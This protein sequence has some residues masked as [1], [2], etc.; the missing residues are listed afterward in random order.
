MVTPDQFRN[1]YKFT[2]V[3]NPWSRVF[4]WYKNVMR[5]EPHRKRLGVPDDCSFGDFLSLDFDQDALRS[6][7][8]WISDGKGQ[9]RMDFIGRFENLAEDFAHVC[10]VL[11]IEDSTLPKLVAGDG[12]HYTDYY[13][14][15]ARE[16]VRRRY[17]DEIALCGFKYG[18]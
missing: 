17:Q 15:K 9:N 10:S 5:F 1:Y 2:F 13:D 8:Y 7:I 18:E 12:S 3:R 16:I 6:Q 11:H 4:S 14:D